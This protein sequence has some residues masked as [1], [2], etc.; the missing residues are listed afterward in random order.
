MQRNE[1]YQGL[2]KYTADNLSTRFLISMDDLRNA[3]PDLARR[4]VRNPIE[5]MLVFEAAVKEV[6]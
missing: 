4:L 1:K 6:S 2:L 3:D 5:T